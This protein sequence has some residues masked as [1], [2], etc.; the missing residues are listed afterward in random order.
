MN[1]NDIKQKLNYMLP[2]K[3]MVHSLN[4]ADC[5]VKLCEIYD[6][7]KDTAY[8]AGVVHDCAKYL[9]KEE[10]S[11]YVNKYN[12]PLDEYERDSLALSHSI[13]GSYIAENEFNITDKEIISAIRYHTTG[14][15][16]MTLL[17]K[18][19]YIADLIE[20]NRDFP[21]VDTLRELVYNKRL[22]EALL[23]SFDNTIKFVIDNKQTIHPRTVNARN[24]IMKTLV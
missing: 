9:D 6:C 7:D 4:V 11:Y 21:Y 23:L 19:I 2:E 16:N 3:R 18:I 12:I 22:N 24:Y 14:K 1:L 15:E 13:I 20:V 10:V 5:A 8:V 17:E